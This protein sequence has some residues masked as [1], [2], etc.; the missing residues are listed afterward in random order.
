VTL[1]QSLNVVQIILSI[2]LI[3]VILMQSKHAGLGGLTGGD[4]GG[5]FRSRRGVEKVLFYLAIVISILFFAM[6][7]VSV[8]ALK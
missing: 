7:L 1:F 6:S 8:F 2:A 5:V 3:A 4:S